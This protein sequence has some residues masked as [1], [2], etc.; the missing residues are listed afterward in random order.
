MDGYCCIWCKAFVIHRGGH[1]TTA[2]KSTSA[3]DAVCQQIGLRFR[4]GWGWWGQSNALVLYPS[5]RRYRSWSWL[6]KAI[7]LFSLWRDTLKYYQ[8]C[9]EFNSRMQWSL[10]WKSVQVLSSSKRGFSKIYLYVTACLSFCLFS[11]KKVLMWNAFKFTDKNRCWF[12]DREVL[13]GLWSQGRVRKR[14]G[15]FSP[16]L[17]DAQESSQV[18]LLLLQLKKILGSVNVMIGE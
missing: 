6:G 5:P 3:S 15:T 7:F 18:K 14:T 4:W 2:P 9:I 1:W 10:A 11:K 13:S 12:S 16:R 17:P 8:V